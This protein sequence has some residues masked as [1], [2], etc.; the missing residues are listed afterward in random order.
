MAP[1][2]RPTRLTSAA[3]ESGDAANRLHEVL[4]DE[5]DN[6]NRVI[7]AGHREERCQRREYADVRGLLTMLPTRIE[8]VHA[9]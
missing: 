9:F 8:L 7:V 2:R 4:N 5:R 3:N 6:R 1:T